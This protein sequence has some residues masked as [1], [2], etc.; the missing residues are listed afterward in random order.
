MKFIG[1]YTD[2]CCFFDKNIADTEK[3]KY[4]FIKNL[5]EWRKSGVNLITAGL[6]SPN[7]FAEYYKKAREQDKTKDISFD[8]SGIKPDGSLDLDYLENAGEIIKEANKYGFCVLVN[9]LSPACENIF[10]DEYAIVNGIFNAVDWLLEK[11]F[12]NILVNITDIS[13]TFYKSSVLNPGGIIRILKSIKSLRSLKEKK[14]RTGNNI[15]FGA[16]IK[17]FA[18]V[19]EK[20]ISEYI[21]FSDFIPVYAD[22]TKKMLEKIYFFQARTQAKNKKIPMVVVKGDDLSDKH[23]SYGK[24]NLAEASENNASWCYYDRDGFVILQ[25]KSKSIDWD[26]N[27]SPAKKR[28]FKAAET[29]V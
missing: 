4:E 1:V 13:H 29:I 9:L 24:N 10:E 3:I 14:E 28:F 18:G 12:S 19:G 8:S 17:S 21:K 15:I 27:S 23:N 6:Q 20:N 26:K 25:T 11:N 5:P 7:P 16:G 2:M 22:N